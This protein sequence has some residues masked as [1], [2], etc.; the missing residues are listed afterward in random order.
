VSRSAEVPA[1]TAAQA[2]LTENVVRT[3]MSPAEEAEAAARLLAEFA[4]D[5]D[6]TARRLGWSRKRLPVSCTVPSSFAHG[7]SWLVTSGMPVFCYPIR[8]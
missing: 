2:A 1:G 7:R 6:E 8:E 4:N 5:R 3:N